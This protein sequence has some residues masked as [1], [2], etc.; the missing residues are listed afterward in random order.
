MGREVKRVPLDFDY[1]YGKMIWK[2]YHNPYRGLKCKLCDGKGT[3]KEYQDLEDSWYYGGWS[4]NLSQEDV[5]VLIDNNRLWDFT[6][7]PITDEQKLIVEE[8]IEDGL[9]S[10]LPYDN[11]YI[12][13]ADEVNKWSKKGLVQDSSNKWY[14]VEAKAKRLGIE[15]N[16]PDC[17][18]EGEFYPTEE[19]KQLAEN[20]ER[21]DPP[22]GEGYQLWETTSEG[23]P[24]SPVFDTPE[25][26]ASWLYENKISSFGHDTATYDEWLN[27]INNHS[28]CLDMII[29]GDG[30]KTGINTV[31]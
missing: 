9:N 1:P 12:P 15:I 18:G 11:G 23:S 28:Y 16:C 8:S 26:L 7:I 19:Y 29:D 14:C 5:Q 22:E 31:L 27:F 20:F 30:I 24:Y 3:S 6:R 13:T 21:I 4:Y 17:K 10:R 2:G 25:K